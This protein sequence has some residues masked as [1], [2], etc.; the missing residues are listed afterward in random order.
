MSKRRSKPILNQPLTPSQVESVVRAAMGR[1]P[2]GG[3]RYEYGV[4]RKGPVRR[5]RCDRCKKTWKFSD[6]LNY[7]PCPGC[8][9]GRL[10]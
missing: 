1:S 7:S 3:G 5:L 4:Y 2:Y 10:S 9:E 6:K 8:K